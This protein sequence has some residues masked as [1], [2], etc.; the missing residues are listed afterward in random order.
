M[1][2]VTDGGQPMFTLNTDNTTYCFHV[3]PSGH[4]EHLYY[5]ARI[6][7]GGDFRNAAQM[8]VKYPAGNLISY[9]KE[10]KELNLENVCQEISTHGKGDIREA[11]L[12]ITYPDGNLTSDF[13]Y[14]SYRIY[15][16]DGNDDNSCGNDAEIKGMPSAQGADEEAVITLKAKDYNVWLKLIYGIFENCGC[17][18]RSARLI[19]GENAD[20]LADRLLSCQVDFPDGDF[21]FINFSGAWAR[22]MNATR[23]HVPDGFVVNSSKTGTSGSRHNPFVVLARRGTDENS[24]EAYG[25]NLVYS[26]NHYESAGLNSFGKLRFLSGINPDGFQAS[27]APQSEFQ[28]PQAVLT[29]SKEGLNGMSANMH[30]FVREHIVRGKWKNRPRPV[31]FNSWEAAYFKFNE[32][33]LLGM[34]KTA[35]ELGIETFVMDDGWFGKRDNDSCSLGDW[36]VNKKKIPDGLS[37]FAGKLKKIGL[38]FGIW[39][40]PEMV[41]EDSDLY[42]THPEWAVRMHG[43][44]HSEGRNQMLLNLTDIEVRQYLTQKMSE[45]F[46]DAGVSYVKWD[47]NRIFSDE[48]GYGLKNQK[49]FAHRYVLGLYEIL[50]ELTKRFPDILFE[51]CASGGNRFDLGMLAYMPQIWASDNTDAYCRA[52]IQTGCSYGYP[53]SVVSA[54]Y[55]DCP[56]HQTLRNI[57]PETRFDVAVFANLGYECNLKDLSTD[58]KNEI[59]E[60]ISFYKKYRDRIFDSDFYRLDCGNENYNGS[61]IYGWICVSKDKSFAL[62]FQMQGENAAN[63]PDACFR[64]KGLDNGSMYHFYNRP[65]KYNIK[66]FGNLINMVSPV[67]IKKD[68]LTHNIIAHFVKMDGEKEDYTVSGDVLNNCGIRLKQNYASAGFDSDVRFY[69]DFCA[70]LYIMEKI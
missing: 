64:A 38:E 1:I 67:H 61:K 51:G 26:G 10:E 8:H 24:G 48:Y 9:S 69:Q 21:D 49:E 63:F 40:E 31:I 39:V 55:S 14:E 11:F 35:K 16:Y 47:M 50:D 30:R 17:I 4:L 45:V 7:T 41:S 34:A 27:L 29:F 25:F 44:G 5:G 2:L 53:M 68:S 22:E 59:K 28:T 33:M 60:Q 42:R 13:I 20:I 52:K 3:L 65:L 46:K 70:R 19:N 36:N 58:E 23:I 43:H 32:S 66:N 57:L 37:G 12:E 15:K 54:H 62:G 18:T 56:N 6:N